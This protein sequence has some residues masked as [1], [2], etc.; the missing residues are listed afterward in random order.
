MSQYTPAEIAEVVAVVVEPADEE[1]DEAVVK[2]EL[3]E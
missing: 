2:L 3:P 1:L